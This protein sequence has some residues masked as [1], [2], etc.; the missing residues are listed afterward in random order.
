MESGLIDVLMFSINP[1]YDME[2]A[3]TDIEALMEYEGLGTGGFTVD[4]ARQTLY[5]RCE[6]LGVAITVMKALG[7]GSLLSE[8]S[9]PFGVAMTVPQC[10]QYALD[11]SGVAVVIVGCDKPSQVREA[12]CLYDVSPEECDYT[13][14]FFSGKDIVMTGRCMYCN[15]CQ[16]C[17]SHIDIAAVTKYVDLARQQSTVPDSVQQHYASLQ[18]HANDCIMCGQCEPNCPFGVQVR[19]NM[20][21]ARGLFGG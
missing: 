20:E 10:I 11:R 12:V 9:S 17:P 4:A 3:D 15:H 21:Q 8:K 6:Q 1:A 16:P 18:A 5:R 14:I 2:H 19:E 7:A 13:H